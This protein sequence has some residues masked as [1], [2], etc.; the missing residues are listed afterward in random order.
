MRCF[1]AGWLGDGAAGW[2]ID[3]IF[4]K[5]TPQVQS[6][7]GCGKGRA[8]VHAA[9]VRGTFAMCSWRVSRAVMVSAG[10]LG[11]VSLRVIFGL[12]CSKF[13]FL[14]SMRESMW[15]VWEIVQHLK[16]SSYS[17]IHFRKCKNTNASNNVATKIVTSENPKLE[18]T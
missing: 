10:W 15:L 7:F 16:G 8:V 1:V 3:A 13:S 17:P 2:G 12:W 11:V 5:S 14:P 18:T 9:Q 4:G 6:D